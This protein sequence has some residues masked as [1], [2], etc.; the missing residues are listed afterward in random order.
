MLCSEVTGC[1][2]CGD[3]RRQRDMLPSTKLPGNV[4]NVPRGQA[5]PSTR[6]SGC[7]ASSSTPLEG[8]DP[9]SSWCFLSNELHY[10]DNTSSDICSRE[11]AQTERNEPLA[12]EGKKFLRSRRGQNGQTNYVRRGIKKSDRRVTVT[13]GTDKRC[14][15]ECSGNVHRRI[16]LHTCDDLVRGVRMSIRG[17]EILHIHITQDR[18]IHR[19]KRGELSLRLGFRMHRQRRE[20][21]IAGIAHLSVIHT[22]G[23]IFQPLVLRAVR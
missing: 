7:T 11:T 22:G 16:A 23:Q 6:I 5:L 15:E 18:Q 14:T 21:S 8:R 13:D 19:R 12:R 17:Q 20:G 2:L 3:V 10:S 1:A 9:S 4:G